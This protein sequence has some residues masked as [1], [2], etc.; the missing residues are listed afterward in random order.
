MAFIGGKAFTFHEFKLG[1]VQRGKFRDALYD[2]W[3][4]FRKDFRLIK[5]KKFGFKGEQSKLKA[6]EME[7]LPR[8]SVLGTQ[9]ARLLV[10]Q[11][12]QKEQDLTDYLIPIKF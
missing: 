8:E 11:E 12:T 5:P 2:N 6:I 7:N 9:T 10:D 4:C 3:M 1:Y